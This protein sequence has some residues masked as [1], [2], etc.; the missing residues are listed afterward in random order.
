MVL[1]AIFTTPVSL[2]LGA[3]KKWNKEPMKG[4]DPAISPILTSVTPNRGIQ[5]LSSV[6]MHM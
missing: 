4:K 1:V 5:A 2:G 3:S 6:R